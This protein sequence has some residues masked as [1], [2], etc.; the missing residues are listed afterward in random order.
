MIRNADITERLDSLIGKELKSEHL[1]EAVFCEE[2]HK[3]N[4]R[5]FRMGSHTYL[6]Y[7]IK[8]HE[9]A[10]SQSF[11][12]ITISGNPNTFRMGIIEKDG[13]IIINSESRISYNYL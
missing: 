8:I 12:D 9:D 1:H 4:L 3:K 13:Q 5:R 11:T 10:N 7:K 2:K 6:N